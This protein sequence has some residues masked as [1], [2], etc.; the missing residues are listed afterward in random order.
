MNRLKFW[1]YALIVIGLAGFGLY[2]LSGSLRAQGVAAVDRQ[3]RAARAHA[4]AAERSSTGEL[5][6]VAAVAASDE[7]FA[8]ALRAGAAEPAQPARPRKAAAV[9]AAPPEQLDRAVEQAGAEAVAKA[10][11]RSGRDGA[12]RVV[13]AFSRE[14]FERS[15]PAE[16]DVATLLKTALDG[17]VARGYVVLGGSKL[18]LA[19]AVPAGERGAIAV[20]VPADLAWIQQQVAA[21]TGEPG[22]RR[23]RAPVAL[24]L[25][26]PGA[27]PVSNAPGDTAMLSSLAARALHPTPADSTAPL[28]PVDVTPAWSPVKIPA[29][30][31][32]L[33]PIAGDRVTARELPGVKGGFMVLAASTAPALAPVVRFEW[34]AVAGLALAFLLA[35]PFSLLVKPAEVAASVPQVLIDAARRI[36]KGDFS[37]RVPVLAGKLGTLAAA[38]NKAV[39]AAQAGTTAASSVTSEFYARAPEPAEEPFSMPLRSARAAAAPGPKA[40]PDDAG[41]LDGAN[42]SG[43]AF[44]AAPVPAAPKPAA[45]PAPAAPSARTTPAPTPAP[46]AAAAPAAAPA[47]RAIIPPTPGA[48]ASELLASAARASPAGDAGDE[49]QHWREVFRDFVRTR[50][51]CG[52]SAE[53]LTYERFRQKLESNKGALVAKYGCKTVRFQV[54]VKD[55]KAALKATPVR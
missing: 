12:G 24:V 55:G 1:L 25:A 21:V 14:G 10:F 44:E 51:E 27:A 53:G 34:Y 31:P 40:A 13:R 7:A 54:Y 36:E 3:L 17:K 39:E 18:H 22:G 47:A 8:A 23:E 6:A 42:L 45:A 28:A 11:Q 43:S 37:A 49:E 32:L 33:R 29:V 46:V 50:A 2:L 19:A 48:A 9:A 52:E 20:F 35:I 15:P 16:A 26:A 4:E 38:M 5:A 41:R 30:Q